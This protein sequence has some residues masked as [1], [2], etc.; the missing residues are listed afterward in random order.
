MNTAPGFW[1]LAASLDRG[2]WFFFLRSTKN[3][4]G[5]QKTIPTSNAIPKRNEES[6]PLL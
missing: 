1:L 4:Y 5:Q 6:A 3:I 2:Y